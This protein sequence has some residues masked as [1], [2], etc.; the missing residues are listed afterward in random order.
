MS[1]MP[2]STIYGLLVPTLFMMACAM[3]FAAPD[4]SMNSPMM[5]PPMKMIKLPLKN[6]A[7]PVTYDVSVPTMELMMSMPLVSAIT[8]AVTIE[9]ISTFQ[10]LMAATTKNTRPTTMPMTPIHSITYP[11]KTFSSHKAFRR[12]SRCPALVPEAGARAGRWKGFYAMSLR[13][14]RISSALLACFMTS[15]SRRIVPS[16]KV[17]R[18]S[19]LSNIVPRSPRCWLSLMASSTS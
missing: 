17:V 11:P 4:L 8:M 14:A 5:A 7:K 19:S 2:R 9:V 1:D 18:S 15:S 10:P 16:S 6:P 3:D 13:V 12:L